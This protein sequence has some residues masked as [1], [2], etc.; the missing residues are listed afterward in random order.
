[1]FTRNFTKKLLFVVVFFSQE[2]YCC[3]FLF[4]GFFGNRVSPKIVDNK[5]SARHSQHSS[6]LSPSFIRKLSGEKIDDLEN[7]S[8]VSLCAVRED[9]NSNLSPRE[10]FMDKLKKKEESLMMQNGDEKKKIK[11]FLIATCTNLLNEYLDINNT[12]IFEQKTIFFE[13]I[14]NNGNANLVDLAQDTIEND[15]AKDVSF[16]N[17]ESL[18]YEERLDGIVCLLSGLDC[19]E[20]LEQKI[21]NLNCLNDI[22]KEMIKNNKDKGIS[23][24]L[25]RIVKAKKIFKGYVNLLVNT[26]FI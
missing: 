2:I 7:D 1:V 9:V 5:G 23:I 21:E 4:C 22:C 24:I 18:S 20:F 16:I 13:S 26:E 8:P 25:E 6:T 3:K 15:S 19:V 14:E 10:A 12:D 11:N 17:I